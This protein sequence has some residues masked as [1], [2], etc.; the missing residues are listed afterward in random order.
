MDTAENIFTYMDSIERLSEYCYE[1]HWINIGP[2]KYGT[3]PK[4]QLTA[5]EFQELREIRGWKDTDNGLPSI[6]DS[7]S[8]Y[9]TDKEALYQGFYR[10]VKFH[11]VFR[12]T[13]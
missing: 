5:K 11:S 2:L 6:D 10:L 9:L 7:L 3:K 13:I 8:G 12:K 1:L 4:V